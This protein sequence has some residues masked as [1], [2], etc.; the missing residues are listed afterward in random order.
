MNNAGAATVSWSYSLNG[1]AR[2]QGATVTLP[3]SLMP[4][5]NATCSSYPCYLIFAEVSYT[6]TP[7]F[8]IFTTGNIALSDNLYVTPRIASCVLYSP[9]NVTSC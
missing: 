4:A 2:T 6:Y 3:S 9:A 7:V 5:N 1:T 8:G